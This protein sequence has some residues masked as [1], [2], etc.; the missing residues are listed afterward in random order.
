[1]AGRVWNG[2]PPP[3]LTGWGYRQHELMIHYWDYQAINFLYGFRP[4]RAVIV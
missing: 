2:N 3:P 1:M 4:Y